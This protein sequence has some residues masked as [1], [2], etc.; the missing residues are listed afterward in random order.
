MTTENPPATHTPPIKAPTRVASDLARRILGFGVWFA[1]GLAPFLGKIRVPLFTAVIE[2]YPAELQAW[3]IPLSGLLMGMI[4]VTIDYASDRKKNTKAFQAGIHRWFVRTVAVFGV[5][6]VT[7]VALYVFAVVRM[8]QRLPGDQSVSR[9]IVT[10]TQEVPPRPPGSA[11]ECPVGQDAEQCIGDISLDP[12]NIRTCF[13]SNRVARA[14]LALALL[15]LLV[16]G[17]FAAAVGIQLVGQ[18]GRRAE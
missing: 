18:R 1:I 9:A 8:E 4:A 11:C 7:L 12:A 16:T 15:Y 2:M 17:A 3:L 10:G 5:S 6:F 14:T 13:G